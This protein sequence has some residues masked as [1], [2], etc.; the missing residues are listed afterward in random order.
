MFYPDLLLV[1]GL[2]LLSLFCAALLILSFVRET[3][4]IWSW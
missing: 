3:N 4:D 1:A 2:V